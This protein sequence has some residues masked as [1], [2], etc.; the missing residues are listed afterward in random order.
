MKKNLPFTPISLEDWDNLNY[1]QRIQ[2]ISK[3]TLFS[4][5]I[6]RTILSIGFLLFSII[7]F[8]QTTLT[9]KV[10]DS[11]DGS[12]IFGASVLATGGTSKAGSQ[13]ASDGT[14][15]LN[16]PVGT[17]NLIITSIGFDKQ[18]IALNGQT[19]FTI[20][21]VS[22]AQDLNGVVVV[23]YGTVKKRDL[24]GSVVTLTSKDFNQGL[25]ASPN[26]LLQ[27]KV[28]GLQVTSNSGATGSGNTI[29][30]RGNTS[31]RSNTNPLYVI[32]GIPLDGSTATPNSS[33]QNGS[34]ASDF[35]NAPITDPLLYIN[36]NDIA[37]VDILKDASG[38]AIY[39]SRG[40]NG[41]ILYTTKKASPGE[42]KIEA[43]AAYSFNAGLMKNYDILTASQFRKAL[44]KYASFIIDSK[45][46][47]LNYDFGANVNA[48]KQISSG[49]A[50][51]N[52]NLA[53]SGGNDIG[54]YRAS[55]LG[56]KQQGYIQKDYL[57]KYVGTF[58]GN[59]KFLN[60]KLSVDFSLIAANTNQSFIP[61]A[62][63]SNSTGNIISAALS[64]DPTQNFKDA[65]GNY[66]FPG[67]GSGNPVALLD[68]YNDKANVNTFL[69][70]ISVT[71]K[72]NP[73]L[74]Y[75]F[76]FG[77]NHSAGS[78]N[79][80][81]EG[82]LP[83]FPNISG[84]GTASIAHALLNTT[85]YT[86]T[87]TYKDKLS[88]NI[89][90]DGILGYDYY[91]S[92]T[93]SDFISAKGFD[94]NTL[95]QNRLN[96]LYTSIFQDANSQNPLTTYAAPT[97]EIQSFFGRV[98]F[99]YK[100]KYYITGTFRADGS[101][102]FGANNKYGYFPSLAAK[103]VLKNEDFLKN[104]KIVSNLAIRGSWGLT[105]SEEFPPGS[106]LDQYSFVSNKTVQQTI[107]GNPNL[108]WEQTK[109]IDL[110]LDFSFGDG[111]LFGSL[112]YYHKNTNNLQNESVA[113]APAPSGNYFV[114]LPANLINSG[115]ELALGYTVISKTDL[116]W[117]LDGNVAYNHNILKKFND[118]NT[119][120][121]IQIL[122]VAI[123]GQ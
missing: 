87:L 19:N 114:N 15:I 86:H 116:T 38:T 78:R 21:L 103:W 60:K 66:I 10:T 64:W 3:S 18:E 51:Q 72:F 102:K 32:D 36:P 82:W 80:N 48:I 49:G 9:G 123:S 40:S 47:P 92:N 58:R 20:K 12:A 113:I 29:K 61:T 44:T 108:K 101:N 98:N 30:I 23:G 73:H 79:Q 55:F 68:A 109:Q 100:D 8:A 74:E 117:E 106:A 96:I 85:D 120:K 35:G 45:G 81:I 77:A 13:T 46:K 70:N 84:N 39:G 6:F 17:K 56:S 7:V 33:N 97:T 111:R 4:K 59:Y 37:Q 67:N 112:D 57:E 43:N 54:T 118:L 83:G 104:N 50:S 69:G 52:Y 31:I 28:A 99:T 71:Y 22:N 34:G 88:S 90:F 119:G 42:V 93:S 5:F 2:V 25:I 95:Q 24:T 122:T 62:N 26:D 107:I 14:F 65:N 1:P 27:N 105:G 76:V 75:K 53:L 110:G 94:I 16:A 63:N 121:P 41:V 89:N 11:K 115:F 91:K